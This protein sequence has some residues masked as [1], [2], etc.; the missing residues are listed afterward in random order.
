MKWTEA[1]AD[2]D[3]CLRLQVLAGHPRG[4]SKGTPSAAAV[5]TNVL[6]EPTH[7]HT[8]TET[9]ARAHT[10]MHIHA[11]PSSPT[12]VTEPLPHTCM[13]VPSYLHP[14]IRAFRYPE[15]PFFFSIYSTLLSFIGYSYLD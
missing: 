1:E 8:R 13:P 3:A 15:L 7:T 6:S 5:A 2:C 10:H 11:L 9:R 4:Y 14:S 12:H